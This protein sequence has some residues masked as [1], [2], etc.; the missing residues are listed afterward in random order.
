MDHSE[1]RDVLVVDDNE[2]LRVAIVE[3]LRHVDLTVDAAADGREAL[4]YLART[5]YALMLLDYEMPEVNGLAVI[6]QL[7]QQPTRPIVLMMTGLDT[8]NRLPIDGDV[9]QAILQKP[10]DVADIAAIIRLCVGLTR[11]P[12]VGVA[13]ESTEVY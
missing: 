11:P 3:F 12:T 1:R 4:E 8:G 10:F 9:V 2:E 13:T 7:K 5:D 6:A